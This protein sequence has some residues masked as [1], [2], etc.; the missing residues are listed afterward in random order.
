MGVIFKTLQYGDHDYLYYDQWRDYAACVGTPLKIEKIENR[1][2]SCFKL[3]KIRARAK[4][5]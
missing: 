4:I 1:A 3:A 2:S 5:S